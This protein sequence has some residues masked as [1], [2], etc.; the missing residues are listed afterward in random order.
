[1]RA[2]RCVF[3]FIPFTDKHDFCHHIVNH[4]MDQIPEDVEPLEF[5]YGLLPMNSNKPMGRLCVMCKKN[6]TAFN[7]E[8][9]K[10][11]RF[12]QAPKCKEDYKN[13]R[14]DRFKAK[15]VPEHPMEDAAYQRK[16]LANHKNAKDF[17]WNDQYTFRIIGTGEEAFLNKLK[18]LDWDPADIFCPSPVDY[19]YQW[20]D[21]SVHLYIPDTYL[22]SISLEV[23]IKDDFDG[24][25]PGREHNR[26][27]E[28]LKDARMKVI[29]AK[30]NI[31]YIKIIGK[32]YS[33][34]LSTY[35][36][37]D[38][39]E[40]IVN[41]SYL[42]DIEDDVW[43]EGFTNGGGS[44]HLT[45]PTKKNNKHSSAKIISEG[46]FKNIAGGKTPQEIYDIRNSDKVKDHQDSMCVRF[47]M[48]HDGYWIFSKPGKSQYTWNFY[49]VKIESK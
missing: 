19:Y 1:M 34:F 37:G 26:E 10:Y 20:P 2:A 11:S 41:E 18:E 21:G 16:M 42:D 36:K 17:I 8:T 38:P 3:C 5:A 48:K 25:I 4:H 23:E 6:N 12:C 47:Y 33:E 32:D 40:G 46:L 35:V 14:A 30:S 45:F 31:N 44:P 43:M 49:A 39:K 9:L 28:Y 7:K 29:T 27:I 22:A 24:V 13:M 15:G